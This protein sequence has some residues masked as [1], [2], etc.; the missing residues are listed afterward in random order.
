MNVTSALAQIEQKAHELAQVKELL[1]Q[2]EPARLL[3]LFYDC[4]NEGIKLY[5]YLED[6]REILRAIQSFLNEELKETG[7]FFSMQERTLNSDKLLAN[8]PLFGIIGELYLSKKKLF[9]WGNPF[10]SMLQKQTEQDVLSEQIPRDE[11]RLNWE[12]KELARIENFP[13][14]LQKMHGY[15]PTKIEQVKK[16]LDAQKRQLKKQKEAQRQTQKEASEWASFIELSLAYKQ[17]LSV[18]EARGFTH[19][20]YAFEPRKTHHMKYRKQANY[21]LSGIL[22][23]EA[24]HISLVHDKEWDTK[25][26]DEPNLSSFRF[27]DEEFNYLHQQIKAHFPQV[28]RKKLGDKDLLSVK[29]KNGAFHIA[30]AGMIRIYG[31]DL[32]LY[33]LLRFSSIRSALCLLYKKRTHED[34]KK[35]ILRQ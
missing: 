8:H 30:K 22:T 9:I 14:F 17:F 11:E 6:N 2:T 10:S 31:E 18:M 35:A 27:T 7:F 1:T 19:N 32:N 26:L 25:E 15:T 12:E 5:H 33:H 13:P 24:G 4:K 20:F 34:R 3:D 29:V 21:S 16:T 28:K 23:Y